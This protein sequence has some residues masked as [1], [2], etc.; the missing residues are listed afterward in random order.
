[1]HFIHFA[2]QWHTWRSLPFLSIAI[3]F[4]TAW[5]E[6]FL[7]RGL[8]QNMLSRSSK[9]DLAGWWTHVGSVGFFA[10]HQYGL[11]ELAL[12]DSRLHCRHLL[13]LDLAEKQFDLCF[14]DRSCAGRY[15][16]ALLLSH[17]LT[18]TPKA[19]RRVR[20]QRR[21]LLSFW[22]PAFTNFFD[23]CHG[24]E[25]CLLGTGWFLWMSRRV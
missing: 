1:M 7:F 6:E 20:D 12:C 19:E 14:R 16:L 11:S 3:L 4:F 9:S 24:L 5:P 25:A 15:Y 13:W 21:F 8:L 23:K 10:H 2:P 22:L 17:V 18:K